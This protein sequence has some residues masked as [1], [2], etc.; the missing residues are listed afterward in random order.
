MEKEYGNNMS[1]MGYYFKNAIRYWKKTFRMIFFY[2]RTEWSEIT[3]DE[4]LNRINSNQ[5]PLI[6]DVRTPKEFAKGHIKN[7]RSIAIHKLKEFFDEL[8]PFKEK[9]IVTICPGGGLSLVAVDILV[10][11]GFSDVKSLHA[12]MDMWVEKGYPTTSSE[13]VEED[14]EFDSKIIQSGEKPPC[15]SDFTV[16]ARNHNCPIPIM[17]SRKAMRTLEINQILEI[18]TTDPGSK[19]DIPAWIKATNQELISVEEL[20]SQEFRFFIRKL[21]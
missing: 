6:I 10:D 9:E 12:G 3:V 7:A 16:D 15:N 14:S 21:K 11:G 5:S 2:N 20:D 18:L 8:Q 1:V 13:E 17:R 4:L 19:Y